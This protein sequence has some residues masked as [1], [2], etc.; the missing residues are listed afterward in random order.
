[1]FGLFPQFAKFSN[2]HP[3]VTIGTTAPTYPCDRGTGRP[4]DWHHFQT[5]TLGV[6]AC[7]FCGKRADQ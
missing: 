3:T 5:S 2:P 6:T 7:V 1:M 4:V